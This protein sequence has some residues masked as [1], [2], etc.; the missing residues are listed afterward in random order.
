MAHGRSNGLLP[1]RSPNTFIDFDTAAFIA[2]ALFGY[3]RPGDCS[4]AAL[5]TG[6]VFVHL[7]LFS[8]VLEFWVDRS[9]DWV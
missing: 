9:F 2:V 6:F 5:E 1:V 3:L 4:M 8:D 7:T